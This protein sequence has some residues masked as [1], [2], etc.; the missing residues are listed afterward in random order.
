MLDERTRM[1]FVILAGNKISYRHT[2]VT[3][4]EGQLDKQL[5]VKTVKPMLAKR[6]CTNAKTIPTIK[7]GYAFEYIYYDKDGNYVDTITVVKAD[8]VVGG[9]YEY[10]GKLP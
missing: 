6:F 4:Q 8:C 1:D 7:E 5:F 10:T 9:D 2:L 3:L